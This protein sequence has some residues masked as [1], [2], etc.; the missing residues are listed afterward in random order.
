MDGIFPAFGGC[1]NC[2]NCAAPNPC[3]GA[4]PVFFTCA[5][6][7]AIVGSFTTIGTYSGQW[8]TGSTYSSSTAPPGFTLNTGTG[9]FTGTPTTAG[10]YS[11][12]I[13]ATNG[14]GSTSCTFSCT[15][16]DCSVCN[17]S[18]FSDGYVGQPPGVP[19]DDTHNCPGE[20][21]CLQSITIDYTIAIGESQLNVYANGSLI[22]S[23]GCWSADGSVSFNVPAGTNTLRFIATAGC[24]SSPD[25]SMEIFVGC[26]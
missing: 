5:A 25:N 10:T 15:V 22:Y 8:L 18:G 6:Q 21:P 19:L 4:A 24:S 23:G 20:F 1:A 26:T 2:Q 12:T 7:T 16:Y 11:V 3:S 9:F 14:C 17:Y 13:T